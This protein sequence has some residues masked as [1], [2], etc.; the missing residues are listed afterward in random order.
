MIMA[1]RKKYINKIIHTTKYASITTILY[2]QLLAIA[3]SPD[4]ANQRRTFGENNNNNKK[5]R[6][7]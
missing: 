5:D 7:K 4:L 3:G 2:P 6:S 1:K